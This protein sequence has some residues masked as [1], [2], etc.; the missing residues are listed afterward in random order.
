MKT[1]KIQLRDYQERILNGIYSYRDRQI[2]RAV[3]FAPT[4]AGKT[5]MSCKMIEDY[6]LAGKPSLFIV[7]QEPLIPQT[8]TTLERFGL[9]CG[10]L[11]A[12]YAPDPSQLI[13]V[14]TVQTLNR[15]QFPPADLVVLDEA[16]GA[17]AAQY[18]AVFDRYREALIVGP[19]ATPFRLSKRESLADRF[20]TIV[21]ELQTIDLIER[22]YLVP[23]TVKAKAPPDL[24]KVRTRLGEFRQDD[25]AIAMNTP[26]MV[27]NLVEQYQQHT[28]G[29]RAIAFCVNR[30]HSQAVAH[31]F[32]AA[33][34]P[35]EYIDGETPADERQAM[36]KRLR[37]EETLVLSS[38]NVL[39]EGFDEPSV[40]VGL[41]ARP[42]KSQGLYM[43]Q[44]G[45]ILRLSP[46]TGKTRAVLLDQAGNVFRFRLPTDRIEIALE[47]A[48]EKEPGEAPVK[49]CPECETVIHASLMTCPHCGHEF[50]AAEKA[51]AP[52]QMEEVTN[53]T[54][55]K[56]DLARLLTVQHEYGLKKGWV[57]HTYLR[58]H[59]NVSLAE[60]ELLAEALDYNKKWAYHQY[61]DRYGQA[62]TLVEQL[63]QIQTWEDLQPFTRLPRDDKQ[64]AW[65]LLSPK[66][67]IRIRE[68]TKSSQ[69]VAA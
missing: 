20:E 44:V 19:T 40:T 49:T 4:G 64:A 55:A 59:S 29:E 18:D 8:V 41:M 25:L 67:R 37:N 47:P 57:V 48:I 22:G 60:F 24:R 2:N 17:C 27:G 43:Q 56:V 7:R 28:P 50:E 11:K 36:Y 26:E 32:N 1:G 69:A 66:A 46:E 62:K 5:A 3:M 30:A 51:S 9:S 63:E 34:I 54:M 45:R 39:S 21:G 31:A 33:G 10:V 52:V 58:E 6:T 42:T 38:V 61:C 65:K 35:A 13:Q 12:G 23:I 53:L 68:L 16:H 14:A 15:R